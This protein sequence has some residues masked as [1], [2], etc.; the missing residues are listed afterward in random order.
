[1]TASK[2]GP[3]RRRRAA[4]KEVRI[5]ERAAKAV[6]GRVERTA[7]GHLKVFGPLGMTIVGSRL[8]NARAWSNAARDLRVHAG[9]VV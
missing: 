8:N 7:N 9:V 6:R 2:R 5:I 4:S 3:V 1:M